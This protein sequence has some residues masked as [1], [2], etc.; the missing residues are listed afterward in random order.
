[1]RRYWRSSA[2]SGSRGSP[3]RRRRRALDRRQRHAQLVAHQPQELGPRALQ[4]LERRQVLKRHHH[5]L[6]RHRAELVTDDRE[7]LKERLEAATG[8]RIA[9]L[10]AVAPDRGKAPEPELG[11]EREAARG[12]GPS[13]S[14]G[15]ESTPGTTPEPKR[16]EPERSL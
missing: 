2:R 5:P 14:T 9:A 16:I 1:M 3:E 13:A 6:A 4:R 8:E 10:E 7:A 12:P 15:R 11:P